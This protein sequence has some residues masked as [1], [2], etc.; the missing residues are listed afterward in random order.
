MTEAS[1]YEN[2]RQVAARDAAYQVLHA[3]HAPGSELAQSAL[4][5]EISR[6]VLATADRVPLDAHVDHEVLRDM[7]VEEGGNQHLQDQREQFAGQLGGPAEGF[8]LP[9]R[10][11]GEPVA[12]YYRR[13][14]VDALYHARDRGLSMDESAARL[15]DLVLLA[16]TV[17][18]VG[19]LP[20]IT[21]VAMEHIAAGHVCE[22]RIEDTQARLYLKRP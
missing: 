10:R 15:A 1:T 4:A 8:L 11:N 3:H 2:R 12:D 5:G 14:A 7:G 9:A 22:L 19:P 6:L 20:P 18:G 21:A 13:V 17:V 16:F